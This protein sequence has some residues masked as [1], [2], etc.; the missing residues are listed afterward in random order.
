M[1]FML[2]AFLLFMETTVGSQ[3][4]RRIPVLVIQ[5]TEIYLQSPAGWNKAEKRQAFVQVTRAH[6]AFQR[7]RGLFSSHSAV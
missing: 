2:K 5:R 4:E 6:A 3:A 1:V 7:V